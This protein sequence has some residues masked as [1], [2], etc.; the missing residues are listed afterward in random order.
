MI[1]ITKEDG[2]TIVEDTTVDDISELYDITDSL[3]ERTDVL[4]D[5][6]SLLETDVGLLNEDVY[7]ENDTPYVY[8]SITG[9][10]YATT[11]GSSWILFYLNKN[12]NIDSQEIDSLTLDNCYLRGIEGILRFDGETSTINNVTIPE[13]KYTASLQ[14]SPHK[15]NII[16]VNITG[17]DTTFRYHVQTNLTLLTK[18]TVQFKEKE[19]NNGGD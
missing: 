4:E 2:Y 11:A 12:L 13:A 18:L 17:L 9:Y 16:A 19:T 7:F 1:V 14:D 10:G 3:D 6:V 5:S 8:Q 15:S